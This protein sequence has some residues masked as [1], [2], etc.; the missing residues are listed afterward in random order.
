MYFL[1]MRWNFAWHL[2]NHR[3]APE[4]ESIM[5]ITNEEHTFLIFVDGEGNC[6]LSTA[7]SAVW[8][9]DLSKRQCMTVFS[10]LT[11]HNN[12]QALRYE[13]EFDKLA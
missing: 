11:V 4:I 12:L 10:E 6:H 1:I 9:Q 8:Y 7:M 13:I 2:A 5:L 3:L